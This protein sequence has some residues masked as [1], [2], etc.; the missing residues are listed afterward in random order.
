MKQTDIHVTAVVEEGAQIGRGVTIEPYAIIKK[1]VILEDLVTVKSHAYVDGHTTVGKGTVIY[2]FASVGSKTQDRKFKGEKTYVKIGQNCE[3]RE[4]VTINSSCGEESSVIIGDDCL[5]MAY[6]HVAHHCEIGNHVTMANASMLAGHVVIED[7]V[8]V[9]GMTAVHQF[10][11]LGAHSMIGG[12]SGIVRDI[13]PYTV[14]FGSRLYR[15]GGLNLIGLRRRKFS[16]EDIASLNEAYKITYRSGLSLNEAL[17]KIEKEI[18]PNPCIIH[19]LQFA[20]SSKRGLSGLGL[21]ESSLDELEKPQDL[22]Q[23]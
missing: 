17:E 3:I 12:Q 7:S 23:I 20:R 16:R 18:E 15:I 6:C 9:G 11:R 10:C 5:F 13:P 19:W 8:T 14:G 22:I 21:D 1:N 2:P 4:Y